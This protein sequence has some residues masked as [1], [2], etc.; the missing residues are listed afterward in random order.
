MRLGWRQVGLERGFG[1]YQGR[2]RGRR[3]LRGLVGDALDLR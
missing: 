3:L 2:R 1:G